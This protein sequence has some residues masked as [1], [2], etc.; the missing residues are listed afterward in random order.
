MKEMAFG[1][2]YSNIVSRQLMRTVLPIIEL[3]TNHHFQTTLL[4]TRK[5]GSELVNS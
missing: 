1:I 4:I 5:L 3:K 2:K